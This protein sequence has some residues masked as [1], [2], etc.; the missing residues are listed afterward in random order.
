LFYKH[1]LVLLDDFLNGRRH[2]RVHV[3]ETLDVRLVLFFDGLDALDSFAVFGKVALR[4]DR[5]VK[6]SS[7]VLVL[8]IIMRNSDVKI[9]GC[10]ERNRKWN[11]IFLPDNH[12]GRFW[13]PN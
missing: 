10:T 9:L 3:V 12:L 7:I 1:A 11:S 8:K 6:L 13:E 5:R 4:Y 2:E